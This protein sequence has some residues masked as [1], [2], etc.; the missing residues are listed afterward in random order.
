MIHSTRTLIDVP[1]TQYRLGV[2]ARDAVGN[3]NAPSIVTV[4]TTG[5]PTPTC[6]VTYR[7]TSQWTTGFVAEVRITNTGTTAIN[8]WSLAWLFANDQRI[9]NLWNGGFTQDGGNVT[10]TNMPYNA[11]V[12]AGGG[13]QAFGF[14]GTW[15][16]VNNSPSTFTLNGRTCL[17]A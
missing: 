11:T 4:T 12:S 2:S 9:T 3:E 6:S 17:V 14:I 8:N 5:A 15:S 7:V 1:G 13:S 10:V 16:G